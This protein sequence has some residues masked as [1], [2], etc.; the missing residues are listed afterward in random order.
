MEVLQLRTTNP[1]GTAVASTQDHDVP[2]SDA[3]H[4]S[5]ALAGASLSGVH[6]GKAEVHEP[7]PELPPY[8]PQVVGAVVLPVEDGS[9]GEGD[10]ILAH[11]GKPPSFS[12]SS[13]RSIT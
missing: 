11:I 4:L 12:V 6:A 3:A 5:S 7:E 8:V 9:D 10:D 2:H 13:F 1:S